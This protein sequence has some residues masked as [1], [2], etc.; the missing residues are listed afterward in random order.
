VAG[1]IA[2]EIVDHAVVQAEI[3]DQASPDSPAAATLAWAS[4]WTSS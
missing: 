4:R 3:A 2:L 1:E